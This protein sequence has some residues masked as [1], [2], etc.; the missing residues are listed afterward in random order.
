MKWSWKSFLIYC[1]LLSVLSLGGT[2][3]SGQFLEGKKLVISESEQV[4]LAMFLSNLG[5]SLILSIVGAFRGWRLSHFLAA[6]AIVSIFLGGSIAAATVVL[7][8]TSMISLAAAKIVQVFYYYFTNPTPSQ[9][10][11]LT[12][13]EEPSETSKET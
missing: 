13:T 4:L 5:A 9:D 10:S 8:L 7:T 6:V 1:C 12:E 2:W 3:I 11:D